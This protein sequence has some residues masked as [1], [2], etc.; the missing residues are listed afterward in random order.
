MLD[1]KKKLKY[2]LERE[3]ERHPRW[4]DLKQIL[5]GVFLKDDRCRTRW[6]LEKSDLFSVKSL[7][8][9]VVYGWVTS[10]KL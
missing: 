10:R 2:D 6:C 8:K 4:E 1:E 9:H 3:R 5:D 7:Y